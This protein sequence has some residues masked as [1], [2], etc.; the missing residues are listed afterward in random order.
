MT[1]DN[2]RTI[3]T[4]LLSSSELSTLPE[5]SLAKI[6]GHVAHTH[7]RTH[8]HAH[9][10]THT[11]THTPHLVGVFLCFQGYDI[12]FLIT[13]F[14]TEQMYKHKLVDFVIQVS[15]CLFSVGSGVLCVMS[16]L[17]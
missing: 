11:H 15:V 12:S 1:W 14:H 10:H 7:T 8:T 17:G 13:N 9:T 16:M 3:K 2:G 5:H 4:D 6:L